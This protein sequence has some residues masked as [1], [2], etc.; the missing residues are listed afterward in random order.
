MTGRPGEPDPARDAG[1]AL[2][3]SALLRL[4]GLPGAVW[5][6]AGN[7]PLFARAAALAEE[8]RRVAVRAAALGDRLGTDLVPHPELPGA[9]RGPVLALRRR[10]HAGTAPGPADT[11][12][13]ATV[14]ALGPALAADLTDLAAR[15]ATLAATRD[16]F[17]AAVAAEHERVGRLALGLLHTDTVL[18]NHL[19]GAAPRIV[20]D[21]ARRAAAGD[22]WHGKRLRKYTGYVWRVAARAA[23]KTTPRDWLGQLAALPL[24]TPHRGAGGGR[25]LLPAAEAGAL[26]TSTMENVH[27]LW[28]RLRAT[29]PDAAGAA[30]PLALTPLHHAAPGGVL[31]C[32]VVDTGADGA[33]LRRIELRRTPVLDAVLALL[34]TGPRPLA[35]IEQ[36]LTAR[37]R[38]PAGDCAPAAG[39]DRRQ[40]ATALRG[41][42]LHLL[43]L[44][45]LQV[46]AGP[47]HRHLDWAPAGRIRTPDVP[48][49]ISPVLAA[50]PAPGRTAH[51]AAPDQDATWFTDAYRLLDTTP[52]TVPGPAA[53]ERVTRGLRLAARLA[54]LRAADRDPAGAATGRPPHP[55]LAGLGPEPRSV[56]DLLTAPPAADPAPPDPDQQSGPGAENEP[57]AGNEP[58]AERGTATAKGTAAANGTAAGDRGARPRYEGWHPAR[59]PGSGYARLLAHLA[60]RLGA[61]H[62]DLDDALLDA[63]GAPAAG[64]ELLAAWPADCLLRPLGD[65]HGPVA[66]LETVSP[67]GVLDARFAEAL[68][69]RRTRP[70]GTQ[71]RTA[72]S[73]APDGYP[74]PAAYR[75]FLAAVERAADVRFVEVLVPPLDARAANAVRRPVLTRWCTG[76]PNTTLYYGSSR[77]DGSAAPGA[78]RHLPLDRITLRT[79]GP[80]V[81]AEAD[82]VRVLPVHHATRTPAPPYDRLV[83]LLMSAAH[84][85]TRY[86][87]QLGGL[88]GAFPGARR[89][90]RLSVGGE[91]VVSPAQWRIAADELWAP[92][93]PE[94]DKVVALALLRRSRRLPRFCFLRAAPGAKPVPVDLVALP[95]LRTLERLRDAAPDGHLIAE[96]AL[97]GPGRSPVRDAL[98]HGAAVAAQ[99]QLR[100]PCDAP[101]AEL[102]A[103][104]AAALRDPTGPPAPGTGPQTSPD[105]RTDGHPPGWNRT[106]RR[107]G[108]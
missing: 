39:D 37:L 73:G 61:E 92:G 106:P 90:P 80:R 33:R 104:A 17:A 100:V 5:A 58:G 76:D 107:G 79:D 35:E 4:A 56:A 2:G 55:D 86:V 96:E 10:L 1:G 36:Q 9:A 23:A 75:A 69:T 50:Q 30:T 101:P 7:G 68:D 98:H 62:L 66:V 3:A 34:A 25:L 42:L 84:P 28:E 60:D 83:R 13:L 87:V 43:R 19:A 11:A 74:N 8:A 70:P 91:L 89:V 12:V 51:G 49:G 67:A 103:R 20:A 65:P 63:L 64:P 41:F 95:A 99:L 48:P 44:G 29:G 40:A 15:A 18:W 82:G 94:A 59:T 14:A 71:G 77:G 46:C 54:A 38:A 57:G 93:A 81:V 78:V 52:D 88:I 31:R 16:D 105:A 24:A 47:R 53:L 32:A 45:V 102:A 6:S 72:P 85:A 22:P 27:L 26:A 21:F 108:S 97:P